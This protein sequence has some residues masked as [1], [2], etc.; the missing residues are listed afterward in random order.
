MSDGPAL[1]QLPCPRRD[2]AALCPRAGGGQGR[3]ADGGDGA[4]PAAAAGGGAVR[5]ACPPHRTAGGMGDGHPLAAAGNG[6]GSPS[7]PRAPRADVRD[8]R[9]AGRGHAL[10]MLGAPQHPLLAFSPRRRAVPLRRG[11]AAAEEPRAAVRPGRRGPEPVPRRAAL[12]L[13]GD[14]A[15]RS[16]HPGAAAA[17]PALGP[18]RAGSGPRPDDAGRDARR[19]R[20]LRRGGGPAPARGLHLRHGAHRRRRDGLAGA[21]ADRGGSADDLGRTREPAS[22]ARAD[23]GPLRPCA[24]AGRRPAAARA[25]PAVPGPGPDRPGHP[26]SPEEDLR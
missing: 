17:R 7:V 4:A 20:G 23:A 6:P 1:H 9:A 15:D 26:R 25:T 19:R 3:R 24:P 12:R 10:G 5:G 13:S 14:G 21:P 8:L 22:A 16:R 18:R 11:A 2:G